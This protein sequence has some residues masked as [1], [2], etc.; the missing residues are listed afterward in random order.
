MMIIFQVNPS[1]HSDEEIQ[2]AKQKMTDFLLSQS[3]APLSSFPSPP[4]P[5]PT[6]P[7]AYQND[8]KQNPFESLVSVVYQPYSGASVGSNLESEIAWG[9][10]F[11]TD[12]IPHPLSTIS[13]SSSSPSDFLKF[14]ISPNSFFQVNRVGMSQLL[15]VV[16]G[17]F[18]DCTGGRG[19]EGEKGRLVDVCCGA[20]SFG[21]SLAGRVGEVVGVELLEE[22]VEDAKKNAEVFFN[23]QRLLFHFNSGLP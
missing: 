11:L 10:P 12:T 6:H 14:Q 4:S 21:L 13:S 20:G 17:W 1:H 19:E 15:D 16:T 23:Y 3:S 5:P 8:I 22:A 9:V 18:E 2:N 7:N